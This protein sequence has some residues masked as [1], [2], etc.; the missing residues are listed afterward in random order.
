MLSPLRRRAA[1]TLIELLVVIAIVSLLIALLLP[2]IQRVREAAARMQCANHLRNIGIAQHNFHGDH[3]YF[4]V[5]WTQTPLGAALPNMGYM[6]FLLP[7]LEQD[8]LYRKFDL[9]QDWRTTA[10][11]AGRQTQ[12]KFVQCPT[13]DANRTDRFSSAV[14]GIVE[15]AC[16]DYAIID[17]VKTLLGPGSLNLVDRAGEAVLVKNGYRKFADMI[18]GDG[19][20]NSVMILEC[21]G[22]PQR[23]A[24]RRLIWDGLTNRITGGQWADSQ[25]DIGLDGSSYD[26]LSTG[27][28]CAINCSNSNEPY[29]FHPN[30]INVLMGDGAVLFVKETINIRVFARMVTKD[31][32]EPFSPADLD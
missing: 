20:S 28:P 6:V 31:G 9:T 14:Y 7:Y 26:G 4:A 11:A 24:R 3:N 23:Y 30:G 10:N 1:F 8:A 32:G 2:A 15:G 25:N 29:S 12:L 22:R 17:E 21:A 5:T 16:G 27:G 13:A 18:S 19:S